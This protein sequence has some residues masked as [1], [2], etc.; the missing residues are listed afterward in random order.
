MAILT[1]DIKLLK[2]AVMSDTSDGGGQMT[3]T[4]VVD[5][6]SNNLFPDTSAMDRA[7]GR[8]NLRKMFG[9]AH[10]DDT[11]TLMGAHA[12]VTEAPADPLVHCTLLKTQNWADT[13][14]TAKDAM[15]KYLVKGPRIGYRL[16][17]LHYFGSMQIRLV[18]LVGGKA[19]SGGDALVLR[20]PN[21]Q[22]QY[23]R[24]LRT[25]TSSEAVAVIE[26]GSTVLLQATVVTCDIGNPLAYDFSGPPATRVG[27]VE[28]GYAQL[29]STNV[30]GGA[31]FYGV[32][33]LASAGAP[34]DYSV[35]AAGGIYTPVV[36]AATVES[37]LIDQY[38]LA[39]S[40]SLSRTASRAVTLP[41]VTLTL[42]PGTVLK[43]PTPA[44]PGSVS[45]G[46]GSTQFTDNAQGVL[47]QGTN[48][49]GQISYTGK[50]VTINA[51][52]PSYGSASASVSYRPATAV[53][54][55]THS[56]L[57]PITIANQG[58]VFTSAF[59][60][61]P[62]PGT[63]VVSYMAQ[64]RWY[65]LTDNANGKLAGSDSSYGVGTINY[66][67]GSLGITLGAVPDIGSALLFQWGDAS[68]AA[69]FSAA[70]TPAR[71]STRIPVAVNADPATLQ[72]NWSRGAANYQALC[73]AAGV[74][75]GDA[76]GNVR[77]G[78]VIDPL[79]GT[80]TFSGGVD[81][82]PA[83]L[84]DGPVTLQWSKTPVGSGSLTANGTG[85]YTL[86]D[87][88]VF[89]RS[90]IFNLL[91]IA[92]EGFNLP[93]II[94]VVDDG[95]GVLICTSFGA[96]GQAVGTINYSTGA[97][98]IVTA[99]AMDVIEI[100]VNT[101]NYTA[102]VQRSYESRISR[103]AHI[104]RLQYGELL[105]ISYRKAG[106][107]VPETLSASPT[108]WSLSLPVRTGTTLCTTGMVFE[109]GGDVYHSAA[110]IVSRGWSVSTGAAVQPSAGAVGD[111]GDISLTSMP[112]NG[113][114][115]VSLVGA[116]INMA[117]G[118][119]VGQGV[120]R[121]ASAPVKVGVFQIQ[122]GA[123]VGSANA[124]GQ[125]SGGGWSGTVDYQRGI[126]AWDRIIGAWAD[127]QSWRTLGPV[128][129]SDLSY[130]AVFLQYLPLDA[131][132]LGL[133]TVRLPLDGKVPVFNRG[134][135]LVVHN[136]LSF[137]F[138]NP[139]TKGLAY[140]LGRARLA[141]VRVKDALGVLVPDTLY[142]CDLNLGTIT[143][144][145]ASSITTY[146][147]PFKCEHRI[148]DMLLCSE[149]DISGK[150]SV[151]RSLTHTFPANTSFVSSALPFG[152]LF[153]RSYS[154]FEQATWTGVW[155]DTIIG[156]AI[157][158]QFN[159]T[160]Y[161][162]TVTNRGAIKERWVLIFTN[163]TSFRVIGESV[164]EIASGNTG[165][166]CAPINPAT[167]TPYF[168]ISPTAWGTGWATGNSLRYNTDACG[169]P[170]WAVRTVL[171]GPATLDSDQFTLA[172]RGDVDRP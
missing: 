6:Q 122:A 35:L 133:D 47:K 120:F 102:G 148:E 144:P 64:G 9:V 31:R 107:A 96:V 149:A 70:N 164:G 90:V 117:D 112:S 110:G 39:L 127:I 2:S 76:T 118:L 104:V 105:N 11:D 59:E 141:S 103:S 136:T 132:L 42:A 114:N 147:Q 162:I 151:T 121:I 58:R 155:Q 119:K 171:Q 63:F 113:T 26:S 71:L 160:L 135:L 130:N 20:N 10:T 24:L 82:A 56:E 4:T 88:P 17:D 156:S 129:A 28:S 100:V 140:S 75:T 48:E 139:L 60:P 66:A 89:P 95:L 80:Q 68:A 1:Q 27:L 78:V 145:T 37:P 131:T 74:L 52:S 123:N 55:A 30:A 94:T 67:T 143:V 65:D 83:I 111:G 165:T 8:V 126:V 99:L 38:P 153:A 34:G 54:A 43:L 7:F 154:I 33:P 142:T 25:V 84:P 87:V 163:S 53:G 3:G 116:A 97:V 16:Y 22:E 81:F 44:E 21:G 169:A 168:T 109:V 5:G 72:I 85:N 73:T 106:S 152:D 172:F 45:I 29:Y 158:P 51:G 19:P 86:P 125:I 150:L 159:S 137:T 49:V 41:P 115:T 46:H 166:Q 157:I 36:P 18:S 93:A 15:E 91:T 13:R 108:N 101:Y 40:Q 161:P 92:Q 69:T 124:S 134:D 14:D 50:T 57:L 170:L 138:P 98:H 23:V 32:K 146:A 128:N 77:T 61:P 12:I 62:A 79:T 167:G